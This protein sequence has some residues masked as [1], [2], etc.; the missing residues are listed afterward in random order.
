MTRQLALTAASR[1][2]EIGTGSGFQTAI[3]AEL[4][5]GVYTI[6]RIEHLA[7]EARARLTELG[8]DN[9]HYRVG[10][11]A[12]GWPEE[13][14]FDAIVVT[15]ATVPRALAAQLRPGGRLVVPIGPPRGEQDLLLVEKLADGTERT[16]EL[17]GV[18]FVPLVTP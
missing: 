18:R 15:A 10:D 4:A 3:L 13:A 7:R 9:I 2:L 6:E 1:V 8:Y 17:L 16:T 14:P 5:A 12:L 11:G